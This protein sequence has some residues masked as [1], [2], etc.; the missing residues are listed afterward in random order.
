M[1]T[2]S[3][4]SQKFMRNF[5]KTS[6]LESLFFNKVAGSLYPFARFLQIDEYLARRKV[7]TVHDT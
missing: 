3:K 5:R 4:C 1:K 2:K 6:V 7:S